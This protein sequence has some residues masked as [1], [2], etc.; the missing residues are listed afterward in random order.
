VALNIVDF[1]DQGAE[2]SPRAFPLGMVLQEVGTD[3]GNA[4][5]VTFNLVYGYRPADLLLNSDLT[6]AIT[7]PDRFAS[8]LDYDLALFFL[9]AD[10]AR[11]QQDPQ[12][13]A[14]LTALQEATF[15]DLLQ[16]VDHV[17][18]PTVQRFQ[19]PVPTKATK[20]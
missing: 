15:Q 14:R 10:T 13:L 18:G 7:V 6:Q 3:W 4:G 16:F 20:A 8:W 12:E 1:Q 5:A 9:Q 19:L 2:L 17:M 11:A